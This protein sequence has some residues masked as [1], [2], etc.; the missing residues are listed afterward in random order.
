MHIMKK[1]FAFFLAALLLAAVSAGSAL[2]WPL[3]GERR[4]ESTV[5][6][7]PERDG[8]CGVYVRFM[9]GDVGS[10]QFS[11]AGIGCGW[12]NIDGAPLD[13]GVWS[14]AGYDLVQAAIDAQGAIPFAAEALDADGNTL[15]KEIFI[16]PSSQ[17]RLF[18]TVS[19]D[20]MT[21]STSAAPDAQADV[22]P[23]PV[24]FI[25]DEIDQNMPIGTAGSSLIAVQEAVKMLE[26]GANTGLG[27]DEIEAAARAWLDVYG[28][29]GPADFIDRLSLVYDAYCQLLTGSAQSL[30]ETAG[31]ADADISRIGEAAAPIE[32]ILRAA[33]LRD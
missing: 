13:E 6:A 20:G 18:I 2:E 21:C 15:A 1:G 19:A 11:Y 9:R 5:I 12:E 7:D 27:A 29:V 30:L 4:I 26:W 3:G 8:E 33:G 22:A 23:L 24:P 31:C 16:Y 17:D 32:A 25:L 28:G 14:Y 10:I